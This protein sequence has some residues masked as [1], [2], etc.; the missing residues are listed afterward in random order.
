MKKIIIMLAVII[1]A[2]CARS[3]QL[4]TQLPQSQ[5]FT[6]DEHLI[7]VFYDGSGS[8]GRPEEMTVLGNTWHFTAHKDEMMDTPVITAYRMG[9]W[10]LSGRMVS[11]SL[12]VYL[13]FSQ[14]DMER[15]CVYGHDFPARTAMLRV[16]KNPPIRTNENGC[17]DMS[18]ELEAQLTSNK[19]L[20]VRGVEWPEDR[21]TT[22]DVNIDGYGTLVKFLRLTR[23]NIENG[24]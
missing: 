2:G 1:I 14:S 11:H 3:S 7:K 20:K 8:F 12:G 22:T 5:T 15:I 24:M 10:S 21:E 6:L 17:V 4:T 9:Q 16:G 19:L 18:E 23:T 13:D